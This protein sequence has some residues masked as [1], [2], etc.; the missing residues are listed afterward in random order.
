MK[1][2]NF[3]YNPDKTVD[4]VEIDTQVR[5]LGRAQNSLAHKH[6]KESI[7]AQL[8]SNEIHIVRRRRFLEGNDFIL[9]TTLRIDFLDGGSRRMEQNLSENVLYW[10]KIT[11]V[12][13][14]FS[15]F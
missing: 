11:N 8:P 6:R 13:V 14:M 10:S 9:R 1:K 2:G 7:N 3:T 12:S 15:F 5:V 4:I